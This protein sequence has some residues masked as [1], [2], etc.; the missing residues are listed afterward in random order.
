MGLSVLDM[1]LYLQTEYYK[2]HERAVSAISMNKEHYKYLTR[3]LN[4]KNLNNLHGMQ[5]IISQSTNLKL[6]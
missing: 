5:I 2:K 3:E 1:I 6:F 4:V